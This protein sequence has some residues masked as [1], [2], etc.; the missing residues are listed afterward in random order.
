[1]SDRWSGIVVKANAVGGIASVSGQWTVP[2]INP[3]LS[4]TSSCYIWI[5]I[6]G[7]EDG[8]IYLLQAGIA[9]DVKGAKVSIEAFWEWIP[10]EPNRVAG[11]DF[12]VSARDT[13]VCKISGQLGTNTAT[14][15]LQNLNARKFAP[16]TNAVRGMNGDYTVRGKSGVSL[17]GN[18]A[19]W[20]VEAPTDNNIPAILCNYGQVQFSGCSAFDKSANTT[21]DPNESTAAAVYLQQNNQTVSRGSS[22]DRGQVIC[23]YGS[24]TSRSLPAPNAISSRALPAENAIASRSFNAGSP[25]HLT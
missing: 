17:Q 8:S 13:I 19:E 20:I 6:D 23:N 11:K 5:G 21:L 25:L 15:S 18:Y 2:D 10:G 14:I 9:C 7:W 24:N 3:T 1:M 12:L 4:G 22:P 16:F